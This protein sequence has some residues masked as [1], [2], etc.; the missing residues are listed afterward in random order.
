MHGL[1]T[2]YTTVAWPRGAG[3]SFCVCVGSLLFICGIFGIHSNSR[4]CRRGNSEQSRSFRKWPILVTM[5]GARVL[6]KVNSCYCR[7][8]LAVTHLGA[9][10]PPTF[11][12]CSPRYVLW[13][14]HTY[15]SSINHLE[16]SSLLPTFRRPP[17][18]YCSYCSWEY[19]KRSFCL[20]LLNS[21]RWLA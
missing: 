15:F 3:R 11:M 12:Y 5:S 14:Q 10:P 21:N 1:L 8:I 4:C 9:N 17:R 18:Y 16:R 13:F 2:Q 19:W 7:V 6:N 20:E